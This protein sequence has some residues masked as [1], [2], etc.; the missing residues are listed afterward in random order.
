MT[1]KKLGTWAVIIFIAYYLFSNPTGAAHFTHNLLDLIK[2]AG[3]SLATFLN[4]L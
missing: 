2:Q 1:L 3:S 4:S